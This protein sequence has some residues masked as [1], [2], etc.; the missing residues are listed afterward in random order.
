M[1]QSAQIAHTRPKSMCAHR[2][3]LSIRYRGIGRLALARTVQ[4]WHCLLLLIVCIS[5]VLCSAFTCSLFCLSLI[6]WET[7]GA[8][9]KR[10]LKE[11]K[12]IKK[13]RS[14]TTSFAAFL[15]SD[16]I[17]YLCIYLCRS[18]EDWIRFN[19]ISNRSCSYCYF[20]SIKFACELVF[21][22]FDFSKPKLALKIVEKKFHVFVFF[23]QLVLCSPSPNAIVWRCDV[24]SKSEISS[25]TRDENKIKLQ[26]RTAGI[27]I[28]LYLFYQNA[29]ITRNGVIILFA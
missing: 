6:R 11:K 5:I 4:L 24:E 28:I 13:K 1:Q 3:K 9:E 26:F 8:D 22:L 16:A 14:E 21:F 29:P 20:D 2:P 7:F 25:T 18:T 27:E 15:I 12:K 19:S 17:I 23:I 10:S